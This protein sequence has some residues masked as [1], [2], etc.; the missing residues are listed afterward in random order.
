MLSR[1]ISKEIIRLSVMAI[2]KVLL[3]GHQL[4]AGMQV[5]LEG[6]L[7][8]CHDWKP[9]YLLTYLASSI[10][11]RNASKPSVDCLTH[12]YVDDTTLTELLPRGS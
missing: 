7:D 6:N 9:N 5:N 10:S 1:Q 8:D 4:V 12:K 11:S 3:W 2:I